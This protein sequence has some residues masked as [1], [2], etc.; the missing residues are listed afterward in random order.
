MA[1]ETQDGVELRNSVDNT[2]AEAGLKQ[3]ES[4]AAETA[5]KISD[6]AA[7]ET[8]RAERQEEAAE[9][10]RDA[11]L[12]RRVMVGLTLGTA[13][14]D[15]AGQSLRMAGY[16]DTGQALSGAADGAR[17]LGT[18]LAPL[19]WQAA[20]A[21]AALGAVGGALKSLADS[22]AE[23]RKRMAE[24]TQSLKDA[25][26]ARAI[27][28]SHLE[29]PEQK[30]EYQHAAR[31]RMDDLR[32]KLD[33]GATISEKDVTDA[34]RWDANLAREL[35]ARN[36]E[37]NGGRLAE[38][39]APMEQLYSG[40]GLKELRRDAKWYDEQLA[41]AEKAGHRPDR[42]FLRRRDMAHSQLEQVKA[43]GP[44][45]LKTAR[46]GTGYDAEADRVYAELH[47]PKDETE[48]LSGSKEEE[49]PRGS[50]LSAKA[51]SLSASGIGYTGNPMQTTENLLRE[52]RDDARRSLATPTLNVAAV[53]SPGTQP[54]ESTSGLLA[55]LREIRDDAR[56]NA[57]NP[58]IGVLTV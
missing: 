29:T 4:A 19:G 22:G 51:D 43:L 36:K 37:Q 35:L 14:L 25:G 12:K 6:N 55:V 49:P 23:A 5:R 50:V 56:R 30:A 18:M 46:R 2:S 53:P 28:E 45:I 17:K 54:Q 26:A 32:I 52:I 34:A 41:E 20:A 38:P 21:G 8:A 42:D 1:A 39:L 48:S 3:L 7:K 40:G 9:R 57:R 15:I 24:L 47:K 10:S 13:G 44:E 16:E 58:A 11:R 27:E 31:V 33:K